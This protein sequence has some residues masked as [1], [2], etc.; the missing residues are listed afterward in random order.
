MKTITNWRLLPLVGGCLVL[1]LL[2]GCK[3]APTV[4]KTYTFFPPSPDEPRIQFLTA[5]ASDADLGR[6]HSFE[7]YITGEQKTTD[8][9][10][11]P[12]GLAAHDGKI[13]VCD[14][15]AGKIEV[16]DLKKRRAILF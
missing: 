8:P 15:V 10:I 12:Y 16:F 13:F 9:L 4:P 6:G 14:T 1:M 5:F 3:T 7:D 2:G 11:K